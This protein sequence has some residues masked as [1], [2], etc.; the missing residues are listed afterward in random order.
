MV[1]QSLRVV[2]TGHYKVCTEKQADFMPCQ[3]PANPRGGVD[4]A[5][6]CGGMGIGDSS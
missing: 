4:A 6:L 3:Q 1:G 5:V 2:A